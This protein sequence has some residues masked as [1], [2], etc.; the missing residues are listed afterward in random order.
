M[1]ERTMVV[2]AALAF[3]FCMDKLMAVIPPA[4]FC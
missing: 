2:M 3:G 1:E 4:L